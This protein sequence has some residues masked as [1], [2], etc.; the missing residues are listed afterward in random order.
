MITFIRDLVSKDIALKLFSLVLAI[1]I[2]FTV[3]FAVEKAE[4]PMATFPLPLAERVF[5]NL[6]VIV[7][8][9]AQDVRDVS[10]DPKEVEVTVQG[11]AATLKNLQDKDIRVLVDL[12]GIEA[13]HD[14]RKRLE[15]STPAGVTLLRVDPTEVQVLFPRRN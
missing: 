14:L 9:S 10:V 2:W 11:A 12:T 7:L 5:A 4:T 13:A 6:P 1:L 15:V 8:S 3:S